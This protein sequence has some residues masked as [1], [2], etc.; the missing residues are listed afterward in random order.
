MRTPIVRRSFS[1][2]RS[3]ANLRKK[4]VFD[5]AILRI[6]LERAGIPVEKLYTASGSH[7]YAYYKQNED[8]IISIINNLPI[9]K[10]YPIKAVESFS[11][12]HLNNI[13][14]SDLTDD[15]I[16]F[17]LARLQEIQEKRRRENEII[18]DAGDQI[19]STCMGESGLMFWDN[20]HG[21]K[22]FIW[23]DQ[24]GRIVAIIVFDKDGQIVP[25]D[26]PRGYGTQDFANEEY[27]KDHCNLRFAYEEEQAYLVENINRFLRTFLDYP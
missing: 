2:L 7:Y 25:A 27:A 26:N 21:G 8:E 9:K 19:E 11:I 13:A 6:E 4:Y 14:F 16:R 18:R 23:V 5:Q 24:S 17:A 20:R 10:E 12:K 22:S 15:E 1:A 3:L